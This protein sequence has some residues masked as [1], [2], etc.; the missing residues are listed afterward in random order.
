[1]DQRSIGLFL[2]LKGCSVRAFYNELTAVLGSD[3]ISS[4]TITKYLRQRQFT[5]I[6]VGPV[7]NQGLSLSAVKKY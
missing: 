2:A 3:V 7:R 5:S 1:M 4:S 6:L